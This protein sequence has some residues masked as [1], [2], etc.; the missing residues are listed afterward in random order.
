MHAD[1][2]AHVAQADKLREN[3]RNTRVYLEI[4]VADDTRADSRLKKG[5]RV[6]KIVCELFFDRVPQTAENFRALCTGEKVRP[7]K[8]SIVCGGCRNT[9]PTTPT[10]SSVLRFVM[11][12]IPV[13]QAHWRHALEYEDEA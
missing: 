10:S 7:A 1:P 5:E 4:E 9:C 12:S 13:R 6:G 11:A 8:S 3:A 2:N